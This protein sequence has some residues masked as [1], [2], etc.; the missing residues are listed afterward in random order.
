MLEGTSQPD[1]WR[2]V[3]SDDFAGRETCEMRVWF[4][5]EDMHV[6]SGVFGEEQREHGKSPKTAF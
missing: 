2:R 4:S 3:D 5:T 6:S 1:S